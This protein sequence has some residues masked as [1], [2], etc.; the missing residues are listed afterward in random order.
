MQPPKN[1]GRKRKCGGANPL[2]LKRKV[3]KL[4]HARVLTGG[5]NPV[6]VDTS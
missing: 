1:S 6:G 2:A 3:W 5:A 4:F